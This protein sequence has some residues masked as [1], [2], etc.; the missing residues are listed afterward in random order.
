MM[1]KR[2]LVILL[3]AIC[4]IQTH[5][6][7]DDNKDGPRKDEKKEKAVKDK[8]N[9]VSGKD[10]VEDRPGDD[11][12]ERLN[13]TQLFKRSEEIIRLQEDYNCFKNAKNNSLIADMS[14][15]LTEMN[16]TFRLNENIAQTV[17]EQ[18]KWMTK[19]VRNTLGESVISNNITNRI[20]GSSNSNYWDAYKT[21][22]IDFIYER[23]FKNCD[24]RKTEDG[25]ST[26]TNSMFTST[27]IYSTTSLVA[28]KRVKRSSNVSRMS[29]L[30]NKP[31]ANTVLIILAPV[32]VVLIVAA[33]SF[34]AFKQR[35]RNIQRKQSAPVVNTTPALNPDKKP[36]IIHQGLTKSS[37]SFDL[38]G[39][40]T[41]KT[42]KED[43][44]PNLNIYR[45]KP[46][47]EE[48]SSQ[49]EDFF[50]MDEQE[51]SSTD[52]L[53]STI[54][55]RNKAEI[56]S[57][58]SLDI[59]SA[60]HVLGNKNT[61][62]KIS[63]CLEDGESNKYTNYL[64]EKNKENKADTEEE[65][66][67]EDLDEIDFMRSTQI[68]T[69]KREVQLRKKT[70][71]WKDHRYST[72]LE[73]TRH[74]AGHKK[75]TSPVNKRYSTGL[76]LQQNAMFLRSCSSPSS[77]QYSRHL[78]TNKMLFRKSSSPVHSVNL[79]EQDEDPYQIPERA[80][81]TNQNEAMYFNNGTSEQGLDLNLEQNCEQ[82]LNQI[83]EKN[84]Q[85]QSDKY[86]Y[87]NVVRNLDQ[88]LNQELQQGLHS[89]LDQELD[90]EDPYE[91]PNEL[92][93]IYE[94]EHIYNS[95]N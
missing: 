5:Q 6:N 1:A 61:K 74:V 19:H 3:L 91:V 42:T 32:A 51:S 15:L 57:N 60:Y 94:Q 49:Y 86:L 72:N 2:Y 88:K 34:K 21:L 36:E 17:A 54:S 67:Y 78:D 93:N 26:E 62:P 58:S 68:E 27:A 77:Q 12:I 14:E 39:C 80:Q 28:E 38:N 41:L 40:Q 83:Q 75:A 46:K 25:N 48:H 23:H 79:A 63:V 43:D 10:D 82:S 45:N 29:L 73:I 92:K 33:V 9:D 95:P 69:D 76:D 37:V 84:M 20:A 44:E 4:Y 50:S 31:S 11:K 24:P 59:E 64:K 87:Q 16:K 52:G 53:Y 55:K 71:G 85:R 8:Q 66:L 81:T 22:F 7:N 30:R 70:V 13:Q 56:N 18:K 47:K 89:K 65:P 90:Q 35:F